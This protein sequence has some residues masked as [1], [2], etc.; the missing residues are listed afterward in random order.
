LKIVSD[1]S[2]IVNLSELSMVAEPKRRIVDIQ[3][4]VAQTASQSSSEERETSNIFSELIWATA[5][6]NATTLSFFPQVP[7][8]TDFHFPEEIPEADD[9]DRFYPVELTV[10][11]Q[12]T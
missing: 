6:Q 10:K 1:K 7:S 11:G 9:G 4:A 12:G 2:S 8:S 3:R 5:C